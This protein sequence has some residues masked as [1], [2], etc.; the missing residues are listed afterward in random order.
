MG[1]FT[2]PVDDDFEFTVKNVQLRGGYALHV[3]TLVGQLKVGDELELNIDGQRR[4][5]IM[6]NH[7]GTHVLNYALRAVLGEADQ[8]GSLVAAERLR[9]DFTA[10]GALKTNQIEQVENIC[11]EVIN[12]GGAVDCKNASL[13]QAKAIEGLRAV[14]GETYPDPVR[15]VSIGIPVDDLLANPTSPQGMSTSIE[16]CGGT[17]LRDIGKTRI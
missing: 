4:I 10:G 12:K 17:H 15:V 16:F 11:N 5:D 7:T 9:F 2:N 14:F 1:Y 3:G 13:A 8:R 6:P